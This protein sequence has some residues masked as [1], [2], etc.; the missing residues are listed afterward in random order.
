M[1]HVTALI[2]EQFAETRLDN[3]SFAIVGQKL[4]CKGKGS[5]LLCGI[6]LYVT[7]RAKAI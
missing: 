1:N 7:E 2:S 4:K 6:L 5:I 3:L